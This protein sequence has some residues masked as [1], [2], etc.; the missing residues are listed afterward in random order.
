MPNTEKTYPFKDLKVEQ[1]SDEYPIEKIDPENLDAIK[2]YYGF[3]IENGFSTLSRGDTVD[4]MAGLRQRQMRSD[5]LRAAIVRIDGKVAATCEI[6]L[7]SGTKGHVFNE[8]E[9][10]SSGVLVHP[11]K[12]GLGLGRIMVAEQ[13]RIAEE[14]GKKAIISAIDRG[15]DSSLRLHL[16]FGFRLDGCDEKKDPPEFHI[17]K[18]LEKK[19]PIAERTSKEI[20]EHLKTERDAG[21]LPVANEIN[22][23]SPDQVSIDPKNTNLINQALKQGYVGVYLLRPKDIPDDP[24]IY[25]NFVVFV[26]AKN[27]PE[28]Q[29]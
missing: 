9:A 17:R 16:G 15:N 4:A 13:E 10:R 2:A 5:A 22:E 20:Q 25:G 14:A 12:Q 21:R 18:N 1:E 26:K 8:D 24:E 7:K 29:K 19:P 23:S 28:N 3:E 11:E 27:L 6:L